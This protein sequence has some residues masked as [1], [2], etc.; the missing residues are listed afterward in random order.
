MA[1]RIE[2]YALIMPVDI[3]KRYF[4][5]DY[6]DKWCWKDGAICRIMGALDPGDAWEIVDICSHLGL[7]RYKEQDGR[8]LIGDFYMASQFGLEDTITPDREADWLRAY[9]GVA[10][11]P[12]CPL[13]LDLPYIFPCWHGGFYYS[14]E[15]VWQ[16]ASS[17][18]SA[19]N[20]V[21]DEY[22]DERMRQ[23]DFLDDSELSIFGL[24]YKTPY[25]NFFINLGLESDRQRLR[26]TVAAVPE[27]SAEGKSL[28][29]LLSTL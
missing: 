16:Q 5:K 21:L 20:E 10:W 9:Q 1:I 3:A 2:F 12:N 26:E 4:P 28:R 8:K 18:L 17:A 22:R 13:G 23:V 14:S 6:P 29:K 24:P 15:E 27:N 25:D 7:D 11:N 19:F